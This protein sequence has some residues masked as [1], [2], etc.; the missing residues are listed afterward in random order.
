[1]LLSRFLVCLLGLV[2][3]RMGILKVA[4]HIPASAAFLLGAA[5]MLFQ[6]P[7]ATLQEMRDTVGLTG[8]WAVSAAAAVAGLE[9]LLAARLI[10]YRSAMARSVAVGL[11]SAFTVALMLKALSSGGSATCSCIGLVR[12]QEVAHAVIRNVLL[13]GLLAMGSYVDMLAESRSRTD[14]PIPR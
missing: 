4:L 11:L 2:W 3:T 1:V 13:M 10:V 5:T 6:S 7:V 8:W 14:L 9:V 12:E